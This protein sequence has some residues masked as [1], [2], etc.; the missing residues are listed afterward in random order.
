VR[1]LTRRVAAV[2]SIVKYGFGFVRF[3]GSPR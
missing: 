3:M 1:S 2:S